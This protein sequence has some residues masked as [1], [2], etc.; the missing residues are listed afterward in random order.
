MFFN[1]EI[2]V[3]KE[4]LIDLR[5]PKKSLKVPRLAKL[6]GFILKDY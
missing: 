5:Q 2:S 4:G 1:S 3:K 6:P